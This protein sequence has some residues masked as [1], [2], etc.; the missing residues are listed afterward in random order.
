MEP[1]VL[2]EIKKVKQRFNQSEIMTLNVE[3]EKKEEEE[4]KEEV[5]E[6]SEIKD[7]KKK[8]K[9]KKVEFLVQTKKNRGKERKIKDME[10]QI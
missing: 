5:E 8:W 7:Q 6:K 2:K 3:E 4:E 9:S 1:S 10:I